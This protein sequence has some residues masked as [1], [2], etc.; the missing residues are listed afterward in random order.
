MRVRRHDNL[1]AAIHMV[2]EALFWFHPMIWWIGSRMVLE[3][4][5][6]C[7]EATVQLIGKP[8]VYAESLLKHPDLCGVANSMRVRRSRR[9]PQ[10]ADC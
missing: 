8:D 2:V 3:R 10:G 5:R 4:E 6:A 1:T 7:D 9:E